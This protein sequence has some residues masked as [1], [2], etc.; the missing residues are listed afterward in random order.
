MEINAP[1]IGSFL[2]E[3]QSESNLLR[4]LTSRRHPVYHH[5]TSFSMLEKKLKGKS[6]MFTPGKNKNDYHEYDE[7][8]NPGIRDNILST[9]FSW[10][11]EDNMA[12]WS[13][14]CDPREDAVRISFNEDA[15]IR[16]YEVLRK[17]LKRPCDTVSQWFQ[18]YDQTEEDQDSPV[19]VSEKTMGAVF[20]HDIVYFLGNQNDSPQNKLCWGGIEQ[21]APNSPL[22]NA[23]RYIREMTGFV[24]NS[25]WSYEQESRL[26]IYF[27]RK[28]VNSYLLEF[29][30]KDWEYILCN[31][32]ISFGPWTPLFRFEEKKREVLSWIDNP[33]IRKQL[34][35]SIRIKNSY[36]SARVKMSNNRYVKSPRK[37]ILDL[38]DETIRHADVYFRCGREMIPDGGRAQFVREMQQLVFQ[39]DCYNRYFLSKR[40]NPSNKKPCG[41]VVTLV[42]EFIEKLDSS[43]NDLRNLYP[44]E[45]IDELRATYFQNE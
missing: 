33:E 29:D 25:A 22:V 40:K 5:F 38:L 36:F 30:K 8:S 18:T 4:F 21:P 44:T 43:R 3:A 14:Y 11:D 34:Q 13:M 19:P 20:L 23:I 12:M 9:S 6:W 10:G 35:N 37:R 45:I 32:Q 41:K 26:S 28:P 27:N 17:K 15:M 2:S 31:S 24:K 39:I 1:N 16:W 7:K 42:S